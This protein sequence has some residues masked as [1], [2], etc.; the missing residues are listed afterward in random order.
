METLAS[1][2]GEDFFLQEPFFDETPYRLEKAATAACYTSHP[3]C[4][5]NQMCAS[6]PWFPQKDRFVWSLSALCWRWTHN[7][8]GT[9]DNVFLFFFLDSDGQYPVP[10]LLSLTPGSTPA[11]ALVLP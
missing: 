4:V 7:C 6:W 1:G 11:D 10:A 9:R 8:S 3:R 5:W 2:T